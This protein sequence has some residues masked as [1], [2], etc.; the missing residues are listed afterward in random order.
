M[1]GERRRVQ[2]RSLLYY[3]AVRELGMSVTEL[4]RKFRDPL[5]SPMHAE[6]G[7]RWR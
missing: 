1:G 6:E 5:L 4:A 3:W 2:A 7:N